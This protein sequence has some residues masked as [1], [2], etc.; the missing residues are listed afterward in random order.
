MSLRK[1][2]ISRLGL[3]YVF[4]A[5]NVMY[6]FISTNFTYFLVN[7]V[8]MGLVTLILHVFPYMSMI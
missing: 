2:L 6:L 5:P 1:R 4:L 8:Q 7:L 3:F